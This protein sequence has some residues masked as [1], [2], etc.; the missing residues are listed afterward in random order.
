MPVFTKA[1]QAH[2]FELFLSC[3]GGWT[4][5]TLE[6]YPPWSGSWLPEGA[7]EPMV[8][9]HVLLILYTLQDTDAVTC[10]RQLKWI[11][12]Q[13]HVARPHRASAGPAGRGGGVSLKKRTFRTQPLAPCMPIW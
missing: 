1:H 7:D 11:L 10:L 3:C 13:E 6:G 4:Q 8:D 5:S 9:H 12:Q 2:L